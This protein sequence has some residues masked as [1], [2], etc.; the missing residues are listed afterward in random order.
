MTHRGPFQPLPFCDS[1]IL[2][3]GS[4]SEAGRVVAPGS[5]SGIRS[6]KKAFYGVGR[7]KLA[8]QDCGLTLPWL[9]LALGF[10]L[11]PKQDRQPVLQSP[12][13]LTA[14]WCS[15]GKTLF[16]CWWSHHT[17]PGDAWRDN[18]TCMG[19]VVLFI[20]GTDRS[21]PGAFALVSILRL[22]F[23][24]SSSANSGQRASSCCN[25]WPQP[26]DSP[27]CALHLQ[28]TLGMAFLGS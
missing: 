1:V 3:W 23:Q 9:L 22:W 13:D 12:V 21:S 17:F 28:R 24:I 26:G 6:Y 16:G 19:Q 14:V 5:A 7:T 11:L 15:P 2:W 27:A 4:L 8:L 20:C 25:P 18:R 10:V